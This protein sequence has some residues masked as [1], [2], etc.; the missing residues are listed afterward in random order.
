MMINDKT[1]T[2]ILT[3]IIFG[4]MARATNGIIIGVTID[5][6]SDGL[7]SGINLDK[8]CPVGFRIIHRRKTK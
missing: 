8:A 2:A 3:G 4:A 6:L 5:R 1:R 7:A